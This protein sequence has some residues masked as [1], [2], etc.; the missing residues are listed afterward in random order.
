MRLNVLAHKVVHATPL[1]PGVKPV[2][3]FE[4]TLACVLW[5]SIEGGACLC[6]QM[7]NTCRRQTSTCGD[8]AG[9]PGSQSEELVGTVLEEEEEKKVDGFERMRRGAQIQASLRCSEAMSHPAGDEIT[10][11]KA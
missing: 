1:K 10:S 8:T 9:H 11:S 3:C 2:V 6:T 4:G 7:S 5:I